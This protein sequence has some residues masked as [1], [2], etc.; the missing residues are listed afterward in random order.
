MQNFLSILIFV[1]LS[2]IT[3][4]QHHYDL[5][6]EIN[7]NKDKKLTLPG[8]TLI[9]NKPIIVP[10]HFIIEGN[11]TIVINQTGGYAFKIAGKEG[12][13]TIIAEDIL[14]SGGIPNINPI[15]SVEDGS[16]FHPGDMVKI[17]KDNVFPW[18]IEFNVIKAVDNQQ[19]T[20][21]NRFIQHFSKNDHVKIVQFFPNE[22]VTIRNLEITSSPTF[23]SY[24]IYAKDTTFLRIENVNFKHITRKPL[25]ITQSFMTDI[26]N[27]QFI[28]N[29]SAGLGDYGIG[30]VQNMG[31]NITGNKLFMS[32][33]IYIKGNLSAAVTNNNSNS[34]GSTGG[35]GISIVSTFHSLFQ[36][37]IFTITNC[38]GIWI[39]QYS[40]H[41]IIANNE[42]FSGITSGI[43]M[44]HQAKNNLIRSNFIYQ[45][46]G[47]G[48]FIDFT[49]NENIIE[50]NVANQNHNR[51]ILV[52]GAH[53]VIKYNIAKNNFLENILAIPYV[54]NIL[55]D[56]MT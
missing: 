50:S 32:G 21:K 48:I 26:I 30:S 6:K 38:Y 29:G 12:H 3:Y 27:N 33:A 47:N 39:N 4:A 41:N 17:I 46:N 9:V 40:S 36:S 18:L 43:Y 13:S 7:L 51:G 49:A 22:K 55:I 15:V 35:D 31:I 11:G 25:H 2:S 44:S 24:G 14:P 19:I 10:D 1:G 34:S 5:Q 52:H 42:L 54:G 53:N 28:E 45:N 16:F 20:F 23:Q 8:G 56:N 37:N